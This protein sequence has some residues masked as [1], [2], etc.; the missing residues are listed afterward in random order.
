MSKL[1]KIKFVV[2]KKLWLKKWV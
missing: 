2:D 1:K